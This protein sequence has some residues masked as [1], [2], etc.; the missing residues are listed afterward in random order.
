MEKQHFE[1]H[2]MYVHPS[3]TLCFRHGTSK[4]EMERES[5]SSRLKHSPPEMMIHRDLP[6]LPLLAAIPSAFGAARTIWDMSSLVSPGNGSGFMDG[7]S[8]GFQ[9]GRQQQTVESR[10][11]NSAATQ[12]LGAMLAYSVLNFGSK[13][14]L[15]YYG[16][17][18]LGSLFNTVSDGLTKSMKD[19]KAGDK[20]NAAANLKNKQTA[21]NSGTTKLEEQWDS[22]EKRGSSSRAEEELAK[23]PPMHKAFLAGVG[24]ILL[25]WLHYVGAAEM[26]KLVMKEI[27]KQEKSKSSDGANRSTKIESLLHTSERNKYNQRKRLLEDWLFRRQNDTSYAEDSKRRTATYIRPALHAGQSAAD[28]M[29]HRQNMMGD[30]NENGDHD[31]DD[32]IR[33][34]LE[35]SFVSGVLN[36]YNSIPFYKKPGVW[37]PAKEHYLNPANTNVVRI[38]FN[39]LLGMFLQVN[40]IFSSDTKNPLH[41]FSKFALMTGYF[42]VLCRALHLYGW[43][44]LYMA[45]K[46]LQGLVIRDEHSAIDLD[47]YDDKRKSGP[48]QHPNNGRRG[49]DHTLSDKQ[50][51]SSNRNDRHPRPNLK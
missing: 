7:F 10:L 28:P 34:V 2:I 15:S 30:T 20:K 19:N 3:T 21:G 41:A 11:W 27:K 4:K 6:F 39:L 49:P 44:P 33:G 51:Y 8:F 1:T 13:K 23:M 9:G 40:A 31:D 36:L 50:Y 16:D 29:T 26:R 35:D 12:G 38:L 43:A 42:E 25:L 18:M 17:E 45:T 32:E 22:F 48:Q 14:F 24:S 37:L 46:A 47:N 5:E